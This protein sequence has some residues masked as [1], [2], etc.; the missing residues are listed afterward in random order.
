MDVQ[1][2]ATGQGDTDGLNYVFSAGDDIVR[3]DK[4]LIKNLKTNKV[5]QIAQEI[6]RKPVLSFGN[7]S[8]DVSMHEYKSAAF[9]LVADDEERDYGNSAKGEE[10]K[11]KWEESGFNVI[12]MKNDFLTIYGENVKKTGTFHWAE[13]FKEK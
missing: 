9:M 2:A 11:T 10:L 4:L 1:L 8:G 12:S 6:G 7:S 3:T 5:L 13:E